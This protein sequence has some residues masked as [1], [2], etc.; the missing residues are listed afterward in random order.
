MCVCVCV[1]AG[2]LCARRIYCVVYASGIYCAPQRVYQ[3][4][5]CA[6]GITHNLGIFGLA[7]IRKNA[8]YASQECV[9]FFFVGFSHNMGSRAVWYKNPKNAARSSRK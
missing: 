4:D 7:N 6:C 8:W 9:V 1:L 5:L 3:R 2:L